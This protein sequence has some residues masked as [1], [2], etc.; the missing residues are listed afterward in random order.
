MKIQATV[1]GT[2]L[3]AAGAEKIGGIAE[4]AVEAAVSVVPGMLEVEVEAAKA[5]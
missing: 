5:E 1:A 3:V 4:V 2:G